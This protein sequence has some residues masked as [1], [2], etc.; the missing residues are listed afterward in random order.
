LDKLVLLPKSIE[1]DLGM[2]GW[3]EENTY[4]DNCRMVW[5]RCSMFAI[6]PLVDTE[7]TVINP[8]IPQKA[9]NIPDS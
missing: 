5:R 1:R 7:K 3:K 2:Y 9:H 8:G 4:L 6:G